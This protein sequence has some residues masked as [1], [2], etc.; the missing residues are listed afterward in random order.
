MACTAVSRAMARSICFCERARVYAHTDGGAQSKVSKQ[1]RRGSCA[2]ALN[3]PMLLVVSRGGAKEVLGVALV[4]E[5]T[6]DSGNSASRVC[7]RM[8]VVLCPS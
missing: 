2:V 1:K 5:R 3:V 6:S 7:V 8:S 4:C